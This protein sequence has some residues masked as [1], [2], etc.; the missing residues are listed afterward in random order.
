VAADIYEQIV[1]RDRLRNHRLIDQELH[2][3][4]QRL[5]VR[6]DAIGPGIA[7]ERSISSSSAGS[8]GS[9]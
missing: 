9:M 6:L 2:Q 5:P 7:A 4:F 3:S 1:D 8:Q